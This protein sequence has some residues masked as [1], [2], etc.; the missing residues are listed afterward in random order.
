MPPG[1]PGIEHYAIRRIDEKAR[2][3]FE[4]VY[5]SIRANKTDPRVAYIELFPLVHAN[6]ADVGFY[7]LCKA[8]SQQ[9]EDNV[10][11]YDRS[12]AFLHILW[13]EEANISDAITY[14]S[15]L[16]PSPGVILFVTRRG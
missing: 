9:A 8:V 14:F 13:G 15:G 16:A 11:V 6:E 2:C 12:H 5:R 10:V 7:G 3:K 4:P 1:L